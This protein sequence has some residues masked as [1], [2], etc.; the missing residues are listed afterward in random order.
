M[1]ELLMAVFVSIVLMGFALPRVIPVTHYYH[2]MS[3]LPGVTGAIQGTRYQAIMTGCPYQIAFNANTTSYQVST[4]V[5]SG[6]PASCAASFTNVGNAVP[7]SSSGDVSIGTSITFQF[8]PN[9]TVTAVTTPSTMPATFS[10]TNGTST[11]TVIVSGVGDV[12][13]SP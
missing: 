3:A 13:A 8:S 7:W 5:L 2:L 9:G 4:E 6:S 1:I 12:T 11:E 10:L